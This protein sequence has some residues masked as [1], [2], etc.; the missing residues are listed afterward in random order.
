[1]HP[2]PGNRRAIIFTAVVAVVVLL[3]Q[4]TK[5]AAV[6]YLAGAAP[7]VGLGGAFRLQYAENR[8]AF[9]SLGASL[10]E[11]ART[12]IFV[13]MVLVVLLLLTLYVFRGKQVTA[14]ELWASALFAAGGI[15]NLV[16]RIW[17]GY[18]RDFAN[19]GVG[20]V[21]TG[22][23]NVADMAI[24]AGAVTLM[25]HLFRSRRSQGSTQVM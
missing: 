20:P 9:L 17:L 22:V 24:T 12:G 7:L 16:D 21:R 10:P 13:L 4:W 15:G 18:V 2:V 14:G 25:F 3:D 23:F 6:R 5:W 19:L 8:G 11:S 1:M